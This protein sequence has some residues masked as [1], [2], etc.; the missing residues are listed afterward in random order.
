MVSLQ[1]AGVIQAILSAIVKKMPWMPL[2][3][4]LHTAEQSEIVALEIFS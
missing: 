3:L 2:Q 4:K 1:Y